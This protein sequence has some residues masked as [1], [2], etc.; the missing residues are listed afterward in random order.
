MKLQVTTPRVW[1]KEVNVVKA[2]ACL[3]SE[4]MRGCGLCICAILCCPEGRGKVHTCAHVRTGTGKVVR[5]WAET[6]ES[7]RSCGSQPHDVT[8]LMP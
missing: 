4:A 1:R 5:A 3:G 8:W 7:S 6:K 2:V